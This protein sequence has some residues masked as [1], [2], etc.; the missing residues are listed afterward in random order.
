MN[1]RA[2]LAWNLRRLRGERGV[3]QETLAHESEIDR[4]YISELERELGN[5]TVDML[6]RLADALRA[7]IGD[8]FRRPATDQQPPKTLR[9]GPRT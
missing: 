4:A 8:L 6:D 1:G 5:A 7:E 2:L 9:P 3:S